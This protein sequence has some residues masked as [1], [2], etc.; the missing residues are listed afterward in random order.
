M[1]SITNWRRSP[2]REFAVA[3]LN[4]KDRSAE[5]CVTPWA[6]QSAEGGTHKKNNLE[7][8]GRVYAAAEREK[9]SRRYRERRDQPC[10]GYMP[11]L[12]W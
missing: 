5:A 7:R 4:A 3:N 2:G 10:R 6:V 12:R 1:P 11:T 9:P 8:C